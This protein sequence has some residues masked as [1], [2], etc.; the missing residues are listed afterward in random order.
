MDY[1]NAI[2]YVP[3]M[4]CVVLFA[5]T[6]I[7]IAVIQSRMP[8]KKEPPAQPAA[9]AIHHLGTYVPIVRTEQDEYQLEIRK[10]TLN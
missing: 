10:N 5:L 4:V 3:L 1:C 7:N 6:I 2:N 8:A 9:P